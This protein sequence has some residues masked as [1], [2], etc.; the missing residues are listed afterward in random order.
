MIRLSK[1]AAGFGKY[2]FREICVEYIPL[3]GST[4]T[5]GFTIAHDPDGSNAVTETLSSLLQF[6][7]NFSTP[8]WKPACLVIKWIGKTLFYVNQQTQTSVPA[9]RLALQGLLLGAND[10]PSPGSTVVNGMLCVKYVCDLYGPLWTPTAINLSSQEEK[11]IIT[12]R[13]EQE[14]EN[15]RRH[16]EQLMLRPRSIQSLLASETKTTTLED[17]RSR[18]PRLESDGDWDMGTPTRA[19]RPPPLT[20]LSVDRSF[21]PRPKS[22]SIK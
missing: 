22:A 1:L 5:G 21:L 18:Q 11:I 9:Q 14:L 6:S 10:N 20:P 15:K 19:S 3:T 13:K 7:K 2:I 17:H 4:T 8:W 16:D 12:L